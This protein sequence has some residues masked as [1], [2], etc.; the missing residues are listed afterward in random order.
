MRRLRLIRRHR[1]LCIGL[2]LFCLLFQQVAMAAYACAADAGGSMLTRGD[3]AQMHDTPGH[4][5]DPRCNEHCADRAASSST[6][7]VPSLPASILAM[8]P[9]LEGS[10]ARAPEHQPLPDPTFLRPDPPPTLR[11][12]SL[13]I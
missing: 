10:I 3:C 2:A 7:Q 5:K 12:C 6:A 8:P 4:A 13:L 11:F 1:L 9:V